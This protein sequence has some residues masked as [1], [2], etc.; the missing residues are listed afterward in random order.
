MLF[1]HRLE[2]LDDF[3]TKAQHFHFELGPSN[4]VADPVGALVI[5]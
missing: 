2:I 4:Y 5:Y 1:C 3:L